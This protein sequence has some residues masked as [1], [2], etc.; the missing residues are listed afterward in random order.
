MPFKTFDFLDALFGSLLGVLFVLGT[1][2]IVAEVRASPEAATALVGPA[3]AVPALANAA[4]ENA[5]A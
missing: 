4:H 5:P 3:F 1:L 2:S